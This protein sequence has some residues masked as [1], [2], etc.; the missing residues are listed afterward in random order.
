[1]RDRREEILARLV[2]IAETI[3]GITRAAR[4]RQ[5]VSGAARPAIIVTD[6]HEVCQPPPNG[7]RPTTAPSLVDM[8]PEIVI[9][10]SAKAEDVGTGINAL[11]LALIKAI[12]GDTDL[13][14]STGTNGFIRYDG[15]LN[16]LTRAKDVAAETN[17][18]FTLSYPLIVSELS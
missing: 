17:V 2:V 8:T 7:S 12:L 11:R 15:M 6:G 9:L 13:Q 18:N 14:N 3:P 10:Y 4:N 5:D 16:E 1:V